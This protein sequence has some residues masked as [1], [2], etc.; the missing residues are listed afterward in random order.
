MDGSGSRVVTAWLPGGVPVRVE[1][2]ESESS[3]RMTSVGLRDLDL[4]KP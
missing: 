3:D 4:D 1:L 2:A